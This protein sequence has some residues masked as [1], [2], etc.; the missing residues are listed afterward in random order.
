HTIAYTAEGLLEGGL[1]LSEPTYV[2]AA[3]KV[4]RVL[5]SKQ[6]PDGSLAS[7]FDE[8]WE[9]TSRSTC[10]TGNCQVALL[11]M[12]LFEQSG[13]GAYLDAARRAIVFVASTQNLNIGNPFIRGAIAG[14]LPMYGKYERMKYPNWAAKFFID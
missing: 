4:A 12:R 11:W 13:D 9:P 1:L 6:R 5:L 8:R 10:L 14:S 7:S 2:A 3:Q